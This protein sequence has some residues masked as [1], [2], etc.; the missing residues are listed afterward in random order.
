MPH[1]GHFHG[2]AVLWL[3]NALFEQDEHLLS[4]WS[5]G[6]EFNGNPSLSFGPF[7][8]DPHTRTLFREGRQIE[9]GPYAFECLLLL[10]KSRGRI[11]TYKDF[12]AS[13]WSEREDAGERRSVIS[14]IRAVVRPLGNSLGDQPS[15]KRW[16]KNIRGYGYLLDIGVEEETSRD[17][18]GSL[19]HPGDQPIEG[20]TPSDSGVRTAN[21][22]LPDSLH[23]RIDQLLLSQPMAEAVRKVL[24]ADNYP[25]LMTLSNEPVINPIWQHFIPAED[26]LRLAESF[27]PLGPMP[28]RMMHLDIFLLKARDASGRP[29]LLNY[30]S[31][32]PISGW[33]AF[34]LLFRDR[35]PGE[36]EPLRQKLN[37]A[38]I[39]EYLGIPIKDITV[40]SLGNHFAV[41]VKPDPGY[42]ELVVYIF[43]FC[44]VT[45]RTAPNWLCRIAPE[46]K[47]QTTIRRFHWL[48]PEEMFSRDRTMLVDG[49]VLRGVHRFFG[50]TL[51]TVPV[52]FPVV[53]PKS[54]KS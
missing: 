54:H 1:V 50:T 36:T 26:R 5:N 22:S 10:L 41:S 34:M 15:G 48:H 53:L 16:V 13:V 17:S 14:K 51:P 32:K 43:E 27:S 35:T 45:F 4:N 20:R 19:S 2:T 31:G 44:A 21:Q 3:R 39:G 52:G 38:D 47:L 46:M 29:L 33:Q 24:T 23:A 18:S 28:P 8:L 37:A 40:K 6:M 12:L 30:F 7:R 49:D 25:M 42:S 11:V 9:L